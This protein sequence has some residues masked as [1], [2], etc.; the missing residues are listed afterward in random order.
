MSLINRVRN[1]N[2]KQFY[3]KNE[4]FV[5]M[6]FMSTF[7]TSLCQVFGSV[8]I[9]CIL[10]FLLFFNVLIN[11][12]EETSKNTNDIRLLSNLLSLFLNL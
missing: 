1:S 8:L 4:W 11:Q 12:R 9:W 5:D 6:V 10:T 7:K 2:L 3:G